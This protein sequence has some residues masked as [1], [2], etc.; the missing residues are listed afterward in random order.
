M[1][2]LVSNL[3]PATPTNRQQVPLAKKTNLVQ[4]P[5]QSPPIVSVINSNQIHTLL[6]Q[7]KF[8]TKTIQIFAD[9]TGNVYGQI[10]QSDQNP[11]KL[12]VIGLPQKVETDQ[13]NQFKKTLSTHFY[14]QQRGKSIVAHVRGVGGGKEQIL[15]KAEVPEFHD[16]P[17][18]WSFTKHALSKG[19]FSVGGAVGG[20]LLAAYFAPVTITGGLGLVALEAAS[21][22]TGA[23]V[24]EGFAELLIQNP[25]NAQIA[26]IKAAIARH[27]TQLA[28]GK[29]RIDNLD[30]FYRDLATSLNLSPAQY[31]DLKDRLEKKAVEEQKKQIETLKLQKKYQDA[32]DA[33]AS[34]SQAYQ[35]GVGLLATK[36]PEKA[37]E[38]SQMGAAAS[39]AADIGIKISKIQS[40]G[41]GFSTLE[42]LSISG[43][44]LSVGFMLIGL[45]TDTGPSVGQQIQSLKEDL[46]NYHYAV[47]RELETVKY[48]LRDIFYVLQ[49]I[50]E[51]VRELKAAFMRHTEK[52]DTQF[53][54]TRQSVD[55]GLQSLAIFI[56]F[57]SQ[58]A[59]LLSKLELDFKIKPDEME[60]FIATC[61]AWGKSN[62]KLATLTGGEFSLESYEGIDS[63]LRYNSAHERGQF[64]LHFLI[65]EHLIS[66]FQKE[67][68][69]LEKGVGNPF[70]LAKSIEAFM[71]VIGL[72]LEKQNPLAQQAVPN[73]QVPR[74]GN[75]YSLLAMFRT[76]YSASTAVSPNLAIGVDNKYTESTKRVLKMYLDQLKSYDEWVK[77]IQ[78]HPKLFEK[79]LQSYRESW[80]SIQHEVKK[81]LRDGP[82][83]KKLEDMQQSLQ[84]SFVEGAQVHLQLQKLE[85]HR[86]LIQAFCEIGFPLSN[87]VDNKFSCIHGSDASVLLMSSGQVREKLNVAFVV[88]PIVIQN[89]LFVL[90]RQIQD[91][92]RL[93]E[94]LIGFKQS[95]IKDDPELFSIRVTKMI[96]AFARKFDITLSE[97]EPLTEITIHTIEETDIQDEFTVAQNPQGNNNNQPN[98]GIENLH[99]IVRLGMCDAFEKLRSSGFVTHQEIQQQDSNGLLLIHH[100]CALGQTGMTRLLKEKCGYDLNSHD[101]KNNTP[102][103]WAAMSNQFEQLQD[104]IELGANHTQTNEDGKKP[105]DLVDPTQHY[106]FNRYVLR[107]QQKVSTK[108]KQAEEKIAANDLP[109]AI[110]IYNGLLNDPN[111]ERRA[112]LERKLEQIKIGYEQQVAHLVRAFNPQPGEKHSKTSK[113]QHRTCE[114]HGS[115]MRAA[116]SAF[117]SNTQRIQSELEQLSKSLDSEI[118]LEVCRRILPLYEKTNNAAKVQD[119]KALQVKLRGAG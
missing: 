7:Q 28:N 38:L 67:L 69:L 58:R 84:A 110:A 18:D 116:D 95:T 72:N 33:V 88:N 9:P 63:T 77:S 17:S 92:L 31:D 83:D 21:G 82:A 94:K 74:P 118:Q 99:L 51:D 87:I 65:K 8:S 45:F 61:H 64:L 59:V 54:V 44:M 105:I 43:D 13:I 76:P 66:D 10:I 71:H 5:G 98:M 35:L 90:D 42:K 19:V 57:Q 89:Q 50:K 78:L 22:A 52:M 60:D 86:L 96:H 108:F 27:E 11:K 34:W 79:L 112:E 119:I 101:K 106:L 26:S 49:E 109:G 30:P 23:L 4:Q 97:P 46:E 55:Q 62:W 56:G 73:L 40:E 70:V 24:A 81:I 103:H 47:M 102:T 29:K 111:P 16:L 48:M 117:T 14:F 41:R 3:V 100:S 25:S 107:G 12:K 85:A 37:Q 91:N 115:A 36:H 39:K 80:E 93:A 68:K 32:S 104:L 15:T 20:A 2:Q 75:P 6:H 113:R 1:I 53:E 114:A